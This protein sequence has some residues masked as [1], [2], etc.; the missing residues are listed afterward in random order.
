MY[1]Y[2]YHPRRFADAMH[3]LIFLKQN[4]LVMVDCVGVVCSLS[5][6]PLC[7]CCAAADGG[8]EVS[9]LWHEHWHEKWHDNCQN[10]VHFGG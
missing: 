3:G 1:I 7:I 2:V 8:D 6:S 9:D 10:V 5:G 4:M